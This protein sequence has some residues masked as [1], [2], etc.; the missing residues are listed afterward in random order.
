[1]S[2]LLFIASNQN[3]HQMWLELQAP[4]H[5]FLEMPGCKQKDADGINGDAAGVSHNFPMTSSKVHLPAILQRTPMAC[6]TAQCTQS[7]H[8]LQVMLPHMSYYTQSRRKVKLL[9]FA[10]PPV[11]PLFHD[12][13]SLSWT[14]LLLTAHACS[15]TYSLSVAADGIC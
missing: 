1:M 11:Y 2:L 15:C 6:L 4:L 13:S 7:Q 14:S 3:W 8:N 10:Q 9:R 5:F 12:L